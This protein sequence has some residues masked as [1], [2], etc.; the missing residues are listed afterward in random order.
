MLLETIGQNNPVVVK[1]NIPTIQLSELSIQKLGLRG[2]FLNDPDFTYSLSDKR[3][4]TVKL[5][6]LTKGLYKIADGID[7]HIV[8]LEEG[9]TISISLNEIPNLNK[10]LS[11]NVYIGFFNN[12]IATGK[13]AWH[14][15]FFDEFKKRTEKLYPLKNYEIANNVMAFKTKCDKALL[16]GENLLDSLYG[17]KKIS[18]N[19]K[20]VAEQELK[21]MYV[22]R[23][24][25]PLSFVP[26]KNINTEYFEKLNTLRFN[27]S[28][29]AVMCKDYL[30]A[31]A[32]YT[33]YLHNSLNINEPYSNLSNE[34]KSIL[35]NYTGIIKDKLLA[36]QI[37]DYIGKNYPLFDSC[38]QVF[39][40]E[41]KNISF[42][43]AII[44]KVNSFEQKSKI[45]NSI[46]FDEIVRG[47]K[48]RNVN[49]IK[50]S[51]LSQFQDS[52][53]TLIDCWAT[54]CI[55]CRDQIPFIHSFEKKFKNKLNVVYLSFD[56][57][58]VKWK[59]YQKK[60]NLGVNQ[61]I[62]DDDFGSAFSKYFDIQEI[63]RYILI[64]K[65][66]VKVLNARM[67]LP[68]LKQEFEEELKK[69]LN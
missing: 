34:M 62:I 26:K 4:G 28:S 48:V 60:N 65:G 67:P 63:P 46:K 41:C 39:L 14:Y 20:L 7:G 1:Y 57:D 32:L 25:T 35:E 5:D 21:A 2:V 8:Y 27:D 59:S 38:Y 69:Y 29:F 19:F 16:I 23:M 3:N 47:T 11:N 44:N 56:K 40:N 52:V 37:Q 18:T 12:L 66:G 31:G 61:F 36:W 13:Y 50:S 49:Y 22:A 45:S 30:Q 33:Y 51:L 43:N 9:D 64:S 17:A 15:T 55:P 10:I 42:K 24:C 6:L 53:P 54:W 58:E 68:A